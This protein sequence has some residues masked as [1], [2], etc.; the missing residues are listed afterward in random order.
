M[1]ESEEAKVRKTGVTVEGKE[2]TSFYTTEETFGT[3]GAM[4]VSWPPRHILVP[5][6]GEQEGERVI[7][8]VTAL[9]KSHNA[10]VTLFTVA[11]PFRWSLAT[12]SVP[13]PTTTALQSRLI[14]FVV[15]MRAE[16]VDVEFGILR[17][18][19]EKVIKELVDSTN[20]DLVVL[21][22]RYRYSWLRFLKGKRLASLFDRLQI[23]VSVI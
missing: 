11:R 6:D 7:P 10:K 2:K 9:A 20:A 8:Y 13:S 15:K 19:K 22:N 21:A 4:K 12:P 18:E 17:G 5:L 14:H 16:G 23:P 3:R 1:V